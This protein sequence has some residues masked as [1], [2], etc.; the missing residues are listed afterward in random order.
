M[1]IEELTPNFVP[2]EIRLSEEERSCIRIVGTILEA[3]IDKEIDIVNC[4][5][6]QIAYK[7]EEAAETL[8]DLLNGFP[9]MELRLYK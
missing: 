7:L 6:E 4:Y 1:H 9:D 5:E 3:I 2:V 8:D